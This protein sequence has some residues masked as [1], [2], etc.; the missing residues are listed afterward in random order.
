LSKLDT[1]SFDP[2]SVAVE[3]LDGASQSYLAIVRCNCTL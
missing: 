1:V 2:V 3:L